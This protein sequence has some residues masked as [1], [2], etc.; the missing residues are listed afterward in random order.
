MADAYWIIGG[1]EKEYGPVPLATLVQWIQEHRVIESTR[2]RKEDGRHQEARRYSELMGF[3]SSQEPVIAAAAAGGSGSLA[4]P[5]EFRVWEFVGL[6]WN[7]VKDHW[8]VLA[9]MFFIQTALGCVPKVGPI[10]HFVIGGAISIGIWRAVLGTLDGRKPAVGMMFE[11]FDRFADGFL[12]QLVVGILV[13]LGFICLIVPGVILLLMWS[14]TFPI[15]AETKLGFWEAMSASAALTEGYR[16]DLFLLALASILILLLGLIV[17]C[18]GAFVSAAVVA[19]TW[20]IAFRFL[21]RQKR[22]A[23]QPA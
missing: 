19:A 1:D 4:L 5:R 7:M 3:F 15:L 2:V 23:S 18:V 13:V 8:L 22:P 9:A 20:G 16:W 11:G 14:F 6:G 12:A 21:Q 10:V 17:F